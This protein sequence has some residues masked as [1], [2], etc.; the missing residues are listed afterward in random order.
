[1]ENE[2]T[3]LEKKTE[4]Y[5]Y[6]VRDN[7]VVPGELTVT[8]TLYEYRELIKEK[9]EADGKLNKKDHEIWELRDKLRKVEGEYN[10]LKDTLGGICKTEENEE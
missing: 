3:I 10:A 7:F 8:I 5:G 4:G 6:G 2:K 1:M 9:A